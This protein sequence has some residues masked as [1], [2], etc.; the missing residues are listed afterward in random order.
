MDKKMK[1]L[2]VG[3]G[4]IG[5]SV[6]KVLGD[7]VWVSKSNSGTYTPTKDKIDVVHICFPYT[8]KFKFYGEVAD[9]QQIAPLVIVHSTVAVG[10]CDTLGVVH[11]FVTGKHPHLEEGIRTF[12]KYFGGKQ[13][14]QAAKIFEDLGIKTKVYQYAGITEAMKLISTTYYGLNIMI[15]K[16]I[17]AW[18]QRKN[19]PFEEVY[20]ENNRGYNEGY[21][22]LGN[23]EFVRP[24]LK[25]IEGKIGGHCVINN[26]ELIDDFWLADLLKKENEKY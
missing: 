10:V 22:K 5:Q 9:Y 14:D 23:P 20:S 19:L 15:E 12:V 1:H 21:L 11:S 7:A 4:Q 26:L 16:E 2:I 18:C 3:Y 6:H 24:N 13:A 25:H 8:D 17:Y